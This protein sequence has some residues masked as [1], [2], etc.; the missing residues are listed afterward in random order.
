MFAGYATLIFA[1]AKFLVSRN[2]YHPKQSQHNITTRPTTDHAANVER[3]YGSTGDSISAKQAHCV[4]DQRHD[5]TSLKRAAS[6]IYHTDSRIIARSASSLPTAL[7]SGWLRAAQ[8]PKFKIPLPRSLVPPTHRLH[9]PTFIDLGP[10]VSEPGFVCLP[11]YLSR[12]YH[13]ALG[14]DNVDTARTHGRTFD[15]FYKSSWGMNKNENQINVRNLSKGPW[16]QSDGC[17]ETCLWQ[18]LTETTC[19]TDKF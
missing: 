3:S 13:G 18:S 9:A 11:V 19:G 5:T 2:V 14:F 8:G 7:S 4:A 12:A 10:A 16:R 17:T 1:I 15:R 6:L